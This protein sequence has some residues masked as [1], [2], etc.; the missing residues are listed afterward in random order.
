[1]TGGAEDIK[2][3]DKGDADIHQWILFDWQ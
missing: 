2:Y 3:I 1:V